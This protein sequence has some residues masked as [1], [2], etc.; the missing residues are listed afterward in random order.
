MQVTPTT[1]YSE[2]ATAAIT[3]LNAPSYDQLADAFERAQVEID[4]YETENAD[5]FDED[6]KL[7]DG[8]NAA[9]DTLESLL[10]FD[11][12]GDIELSDGTR[13]MVSDRI[14]AIEKL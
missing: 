2:I 8:L 12:Q 4:E 3:G 13:T 14:D 9:K 6:T 11:A 10:T 5:L 7:R 1:P